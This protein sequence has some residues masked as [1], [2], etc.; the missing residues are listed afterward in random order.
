ASTERHRKVRHQIRLRGQVAV[1][2]RERDRVAERLAA[3]DD[4]D[5]VDLRLL[6]EIVADDRVPELVVRGDTTLLLGE[7]TRL[8]LRAGDHPHDPLL[9]LLLLDRLLAATRREQ[10]GLVDEV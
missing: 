3:A 6:V 4:R 7:E 9:E 8:L 10:R 2:A 1:L 5:L